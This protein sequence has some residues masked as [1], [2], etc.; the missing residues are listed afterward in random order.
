VKHEVAAGLAGVQGQ[1]V[2]EL[3]VD[4]VGVDEQQV[5]LLDLPSL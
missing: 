1:F 4:V 3:L 2:A 5:G